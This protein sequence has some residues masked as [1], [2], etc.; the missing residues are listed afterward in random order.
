MP[1]EEAKLQIAMFPRLAFGHAN[2]F[3]HLSELV[4]QKDHL[5]SFIFTPRKIDGL[6]KITPNLS[7]FVRFPLPPTDNP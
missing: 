3:P 2:P 7:A 1:K 5:I 6:N 4:A